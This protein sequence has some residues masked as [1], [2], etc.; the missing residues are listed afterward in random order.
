MAA[1]LVIPEAHTEVVGLLK[2]NSPSTREA[3]LRALEKLWQQADFET[4][5]AVFKDDRSQEVRRTAGWTLWETRSAERASALVGLWRADPLPH[6]RV[7][8]CQ[9]AAEFPQPS[10]HADIASS[11]GIRMGTCARRL[12]ERLRQSSKR[13][14]S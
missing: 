7:W 8:A 11:R 12:G 10:F 1:E 5:L 14:C 6:H 4:V 3:A 9:V 2:S 13:A